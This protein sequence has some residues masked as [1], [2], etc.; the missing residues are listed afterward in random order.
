MNEILQML[1]GG[2]LRSEGRAAEVAAHVIADPGCLSELAEGLSLDDKL[3]RARTCMSMEVM[4]RSHPEPLQ[5]LGPEL[6]RTA[7][8]ETV[9]QARWHLAETFCNVPLDRKQAERAVGLLLEYLGDTSRIVTYC[10]VQALGV[11]GKKSARKSEIAA[12]VQRHA[13]DSKSMAKAVARALA[14]LELTS[15]GGPSHNC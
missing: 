3:I 10:A 8:E 14:E 1:T 5:P 15:P 12:E 2:D 11:L 9:A 7:E 6:I 4:S 13:S